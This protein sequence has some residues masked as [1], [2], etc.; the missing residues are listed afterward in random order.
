M[1]HSLYV[2]VLGQ[3]IQNKHPT[4]ILEAGLGIMMLPGVS[5]FE[6][7]VLSMCTC[8]FQV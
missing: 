3:N 4:Q 7:Q 2:T 5:T 6:W 8:I 1:K